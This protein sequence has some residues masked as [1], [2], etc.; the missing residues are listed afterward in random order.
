MFW[1]HHCVADRVHGIHYFLNCRLSAPPFIQKNMNF[2]NILGFLGSVPVACRFNLTFHLI[3][4]HLHKTWRKVVHMMFPFSWALAGTVPSPS[5]G[6]PSCLCSALFVLWSR[7]ETTRSASCKR[8]L[9]WISLTKRGHYCAS[10]RARSN[11]PNQIQSSRTTDRFLLSTLRWRK[12]KKERPEHL[13]SLHMASHELHSHMLNSFEG[14]H[15]ASTAKIIEE[16]VKLFIAIR[17]PESQ[18]WLMVSFVLF[19]V[20]HC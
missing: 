4:A 1:K 5:E 13:L 6:Q 11:A 14:C 8:N 3:T 10:A 16:Q 17:G 19:M 12:D 18:V 2:Q 20:M 9:C 15:Y 7:S